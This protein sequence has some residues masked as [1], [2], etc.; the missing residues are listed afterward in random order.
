MKRFVFF[1][2]FCFSTLFAVA[3]T[4]CINGDCANGNGTYKWENGDMYSG[5]WAS[6]VRT[7]YGRYDWSDGSYYVGYFL[8]GL[9]EGEGAY[10]TPTGTEM[11][12]WF[13]NN[14]YQGKQK[15]VNTSGAN[16][17]SGGGGGASGGGTN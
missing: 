9:L 6:G 1:L 12:G 16:T 7:G 4:G 5:A 3:Q 8:N 11:V 2:T 14:E 15:P 10:Y 13:A 17:R